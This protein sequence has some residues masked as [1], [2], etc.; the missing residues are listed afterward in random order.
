MLGTA[1]TAWGAR[2][3]KTLTITALAMMA[4]LA[5]GCQT[6]GTQA[7][8]GQATGAQASGTQASGTQGTSPTQSPSAASPSPST[9]GQVGDKFTVS[10][11]DARYEVTL[12]SVQQSAQPDTEFDAPSAGHH[13]AAAEF[14]VT[15]VTKIDENANNSATVTGSDE[16]AYTSS[17]NDVAAG[18]NFASGQV[19]LQPGASLVGWVSFELPD[20]VQVAKV[21]WVPNSGFSSEIAEWEVHGST[22]S[23]GSTTAPGS[24]APP[25]P[26]ATSPASSSSAA[27]P[28]APATTT[29]PSA[30]AP[31]VPSAP[32][33]TVIAYFDAI[34]RRDFQQAWEL[35]GKNTTSTY[36]SFVS[37]FSTTVMVAV[38]ILGLS[39]SVVTAHLSSLESDGSIKDFEGTYTVHG[40]VID[41][42]HVRQV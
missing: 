8:G 21:A 22:A 29:P 27:S 5:A 7:S 26:T 38:Q 16:Q 2:M 25:S 1:P 34:N 3:N 15:A 10:G 19:L 32:E 35:G 12:L 13:L 33:Q 24:T 20:G 31:A 14:R 41:K 40:G 9:P 39:G 11:G 28:S 30:A 23:P 17:L 4:A 18:T 37:G 42:F 36:S 6:S